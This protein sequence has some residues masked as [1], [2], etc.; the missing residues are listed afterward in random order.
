MI[1]RILKIYE[2]ARREIFDGDSFPCDVGAVTIAYLADLHG[3]KREVRTGTYLH[4]NLEAYCRAVGEDYES[5]RESLLPGR[6]ANEPTEE[7]HTWA[8]LYPEGAEPLLVDPNGEVRKEPR[9]QPL[10]ESLPRYK[11]LDAG[12]EMVELESNVNPRELVSE[13]WDKRLKPVLDYID[14]TATT[15]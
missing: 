9:T 3:V 10:S 13:G 15:P 7:F 4:K 2:D 1:E 5:S 12:N 8:V 14:R 6:D 11:A